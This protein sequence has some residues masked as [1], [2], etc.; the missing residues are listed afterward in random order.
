MTQ[1]KG[2]VPWH[3]DTGML[4]PLPGEKYESYL[5]TNCGYAYAQTPTNMKY[6]L[7]KWRCI[8]CDL[9]DT[10]YAAEKIIKI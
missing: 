3:G 9:V 4:P 1:Q 5:C 2:N 8:G 10:P 6:I 7:D